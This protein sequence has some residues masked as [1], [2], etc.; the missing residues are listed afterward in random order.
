M[1]FTRKEIKSFAFIVLFLTY[2]N[3]AM[4]VGTP[5]LERGQEAYQNI[6]YRD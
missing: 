6:V 1:T 5:V 3:W 4:N 2:C